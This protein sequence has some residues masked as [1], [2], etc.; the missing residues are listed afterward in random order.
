MKRIVT[1]VALLSTL[2][3][4]LAASAIGKIR[5]LGIP[6][7]G[8]G[9]VRLHP[10]QL[11]N[12]KPSLLASM[13]QNNPGLFVIDIDLET[14]HCRQFNT[15]LP[16]AYYPSTSMRSLRTG[17][18]W[19]GSAYTGHLHRYDPMHPERGL[20]DL[21]A[22]DPELV[23]FPTGIAEDANGMIYIG[24]YPGAALTRFDPST[25]EFERF[26]RLDMTD[27]YLYPQ[28][29]DD[30]TIVA[31]VK[32]TRY[33]LIA[34][35]PVTGQHIEIG[36][37]LREPHA[38]KDKSFEFI[39]AVDGHLYL[40]SFA[41]NFRLQ[42]MEAVPVESV[43]DRKPGV[44]A[45]Y[46]TKSGYQETQPL[47]D[48]TIATF[49]DQDTFEFRRVLLK[50]GE[51]GAYSRE[52]TLDWTGG[53]TEI[54]TIHLGP[55]GRLY[56][57]SM[58]PERL[59]RCDLDGTN[60]IDFGQCSIANGEGYSMANYDGNL[61][62]ASY[63]GSR[64]S[65]FDPER[66]YQFGTGPGSNPLDIGRIDGVGNRPHAMIATPDGKLWLGSA[67]DYGLYGGTLS[68]FDT[69]TALRGS[70]RDIIK[71]CTP[72]TLLWL[73]ELQRILVGFNVEVGTGAPSRADRGGFALWNPVTDKA[74]YIGDFDDPELADV[75][76]L[77]PAGNGRVYAISGRNPRLITHYDAQPAPSRLLLINPRTRK[78][79]AAQLLPDDYGAI[80]FETGNILR[81]DDDGEVYGLTSTTV[82]RVK[83][84]TVDTE[85]ITTIADGEVT[86]VG[87]VKDGVFYFGSLWRL[88]SV[89]VK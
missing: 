12:G 47:P 17:I 20:E 25:G 89:N 24:G 56:G 21:G 45:T 31:Q 28:I 78:V 2:A 73:P 69:R 44:Y 6:V 79:E 63:P 53:G 64:V 35:D 52:I 32:N 41:G 37:V 22:I 33:Q 27:K 29:G 16:K 85:R 54:W 36:P 11:P 40:K 84:G 46:R 43:P 19:V 76:S 68:W 58:L 62:I 66:P 88:R 3:P 48:G 49:A 8:I 1:A 61:A 59:F 13:G 14:G 82:F 18:L 55:D 75:C 72:F 38:N 10:G 5:E 15:E 80:P 26:G 77:V 67:P 30:G 81:T 65:L 34:F 57:S 50:P 9:W 70:H 86:V 74:D 42:G 4:I 51:T 71:D 83:P 87:P 7:R 60:S 23:T 39:K